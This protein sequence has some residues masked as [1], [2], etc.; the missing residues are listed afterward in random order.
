MMV[1]FVFDELIP[2]YSETVFR[3]CYEKRKTDASNV[4]L[5]FKALL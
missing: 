2:A 1:T 5:E 4:L 3:R